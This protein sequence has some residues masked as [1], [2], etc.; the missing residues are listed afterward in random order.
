MI[1]KMPK[2]KL[3]HCCNSR[4][5]RP[6]W[7]MEE[8]GIEHDIEVLRFPPRVFCKEYLGVNNLG[9]VPYFVDGDVTMTES[10]AICHYL[11]ERY[12]HYQFALK[13]DHAEYGDYLNWLYHSDATL[14]FPQT[15]V[16]R[17]GKLKSEERQIPQVV[18]DYGK[19][20]IARLQR[21]DE[22]L[23]TRNYLCDSRFTIADI[24]ITY[25]LHLGDLLGLS[26]YY[27]PQ[28][29]DYLARMRSRDGFGRA[30]SIGSELDAFKNYPASNLEL[31]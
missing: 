12:E 9:T 25:A 18:S 22:H 3:W 7:A 23:L 15:I 1:R 11:V 29:A 30:A 13:P 26:E 5:V 19:W 24:A 27:T 2:P 8:M 10:T 14:T 6:L 16:L 4:S 28:V 31:N 17:Y 20:Y 21:L